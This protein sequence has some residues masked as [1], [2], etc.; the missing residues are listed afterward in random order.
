MRFYIK[1]GKRYA[2]RW[3]KAFF[4]ALNRDKNFKK[5]LR[6]GWVR[7]GTVRLCMVRLGTVWYGSVRYG[8]A[9]YDMVRTRFKIRTL[10]C[11]LGIGV[12]GQIF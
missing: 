6:Y 3:G 11:K 10:Y 4:Q 8:T 1:N 5:T 9:R 7:L 12:N 2:F